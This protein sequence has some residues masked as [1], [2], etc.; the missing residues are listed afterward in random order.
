MEEITKKNKTLKHLKHIVKP[1]DKP[2]HVLNIIVQGAGLAFSQTRFYHLGRLRS[3]RPQNG[4]VVSG[5]S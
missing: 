4:R 3:Q 1:S 2:E 5:R